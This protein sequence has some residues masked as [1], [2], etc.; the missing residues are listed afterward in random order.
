[1]P[2]I[3]PHEN[4]VLG[5]HILKFQYRTMKYIGQTGWTIKAG[6]C[7][8]SQTKETEFSVG[9]AHFQ[10]G[11]YIESSKDA[12]GILGVAKMFTSLR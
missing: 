1:M 6:I 4:S 8:R 3:D 11:A 12:V 2:K 10:Y 9:L 5:L 7:I